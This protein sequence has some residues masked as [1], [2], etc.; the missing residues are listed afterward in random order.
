MQV[1]VHWEDRHL[2]LQETNPLKRSRLNFAG[3]TAIH[4]N[5]PDVKGHEFAL[6]AFRRIR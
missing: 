3:V 2:P 5:R 6:V 1:P 4:L